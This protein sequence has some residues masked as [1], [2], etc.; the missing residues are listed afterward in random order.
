MT[1]K[2][3]MT[4]DLSVFFNSD[5][6]AENVL[7]VPSGGSPSSIIALVEK[8][9]NHLEPYV[10][11]EVTA[12]SEILCKKSDVSNGQYGDR[13]HFGRETWELQPGRGRIYE[14]DDVVRLALERVLPSGGFHDWLCLDSDGYLDVAE[15]KITATALPNSA[16]GTAILCDY[17]EAGIPTTFEIIFKLNW[18]GS[19]AENSTSVIFG[20]SRETI[21]LSDL[22]AQYNDDSVVIVIKR[23]EI[24]YYLYLRN[25]DGTIVNDY[26][27]MDAASPPGERWLKLTRSGVTWILDVYTDEAMTNLEDTLTAEGSSMEYRYRYAV[28]GFGYPGAPTNTF[29]ITLISE[30]GL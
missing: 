14:D 18:S 30:D 29:D 28:M 26:Y 27:L 10:R 15:D 9:S 2:T 6:F 7:Y 20:M 3:Q 25:Y 8:E 13:F 23:G 4:S 12:F 24:G 19:S 16:D 17:G 11:G 1:L 22:W 21:A 5:E